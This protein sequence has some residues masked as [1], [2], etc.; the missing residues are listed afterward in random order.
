MNPDCRAGKHSACAGDAWDEQ[1][2]APTTCSCWCH[3]VAAAFR[4]GQEQET[5]ELLDRA[6]LAL[7]RYRGT[8]ETEARLWLTGATS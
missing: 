8:D 7:A 3:E 1:A 6:V 2:D 5:A 4:V